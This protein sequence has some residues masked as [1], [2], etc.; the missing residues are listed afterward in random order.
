MFRGE[1]DFEC[2]VVSVYSWRTIRLNVAHVVGH[3]AGR[4]G[5][6]SALPCTIG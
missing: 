2:H 5:G 3:P 4:R 6:I 1:V